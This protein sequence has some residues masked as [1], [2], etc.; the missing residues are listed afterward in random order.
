MRLLASFAINIPTDEPRWKQER[1][2]S[3]GKRVSADCAAR[4]GFWRAGA[5]YQLTHV[6]LGLSFEIAMRLLISAI[7]I[8]VVVTLFGPA[9]A[10][11]SVN[12]MRSD[13]IRTNQHRVPNIVGMSPGAAQ[14]TLEHRDFGWNYH[15]Y[16]PLCDGIP[17]EGHIRRQAP[18]AGALAVSG[19]IVRL[20]DSC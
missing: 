6:D 9:L 15:L 8:C 4:K 19:S 16:S 20:E 1:R 11:S 17:P 10:S 18:P 12:S 5:G 14:R 13:Q 3:S 2:S 7:G